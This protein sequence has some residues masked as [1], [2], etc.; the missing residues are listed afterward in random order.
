M[1]NEMRRWIESNAGETY[2]NFINGE[3]MPSV[4]GQ[5]KPL[6]EAAIQD[7]QL[8]NF[9]DSVEEDVD[10]AVKAAHKAFNS[11]KNVSS[12]RRAE[13]LYRL[14]DVLEEHQEELAYI[15]SAEQG[16]VLAESYGEVKRAASEARFAAGEA[17][18]VE[19]QILP[20]EN[21]EIVSQVR[22]YPI[23]VIAEI[24]PW[25][26]P[27]VTPVR[28]IAPAL[29]F[30]CTVVLK[31]ASSTPWTSVKLME[32]MAK[33]G[34]PNGVVNLVIGSGRRVGDPLVKHPLVK[35][36]SFTGSTDLGV[37]I[38][39]IAAAR[40]VKTQL[41]LGGKNAAVVLDYDNLEAAAEQIVS[42]AFGCT[43]QRC[44]AISR[45][46][47]LKDKAEALIQQLLK[48]I[49][50]IRIGPAWDEAATMGPLIDKK[51]YESVMNY[52]ELGKQEGAALITGGE[53]LLV[54]NHE[55]G[56]YIAP[57]LFTK[58]TPE[59]T[60]AKEEIFGPVLVVLEAKDIDE[61]VDIANATEYGL[62]ASVFTNT[63]ETAQKLSDSLENGMV[64]VN[65][66]TS[67]QAHIPF[68]G[69]K[70]SGY[71]AFSIGHSNQEFFT[72]LKAVYVKGR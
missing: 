47:V 8:G 52:I 39:Q 53:R 17:S 57:T 1:S 12:S 24:A 2:K 3:W 34:V 54:N 68:G 27:L 6:Y 41:E 38:N 19:G 66:G 69:V 16:K 36:V 67:S 21:P 40:L 26:F 13:I 30:G 64:H 4:S 29:A 59:M 62:A 18:R 32:L 60:I 49:S 46:I 15:L 58:V 63:L 51:Q 43:G 5:T 35:G 70:K 14:A 37:S 31:P 7:H 44:T 10:L 23:G 55:D 48:K 65:H 71:G 20:S 28:K 45:V 50:S 25:N 11:W 72:T 33:A 56:Y 9:P 42:A 61:A 22:P